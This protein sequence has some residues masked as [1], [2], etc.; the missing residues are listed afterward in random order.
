MIVPPQDVREAVRIGQQRM[1]INLAFWGEE[2]CTNGRFICKSEARGA[3]AGG[4]AEDWQWKGSL[5]LWDGGG[6]G[7]GQAAPVALSLREIERP[8]AALGEGVA[9]EGEGSGDGG[10]A[11]S[12]SLSQLRVG[13]L[14]RLGQQR[15]VA[16][17]A[18]DRAM[19]SDDARAALTALLTMGEE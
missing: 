12:G 8:W 17:E 7:A 6:G 3:E 16:D 9:D 10:A 5:P 4:A 11:G 18:L 19:E 15:G 2:A 14:M 13:E 1:S